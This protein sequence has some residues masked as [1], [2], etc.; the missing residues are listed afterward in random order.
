MIV[1]RM[2]GAAGRSPLSTASLGVTMCDASHPLFECDKL[3]AYATLEE[4]DAH[5][6][7]FERIGKHL[8]S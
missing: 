5:A 8:N 4:V 1:G 2:G 3:P 7:T 6:S